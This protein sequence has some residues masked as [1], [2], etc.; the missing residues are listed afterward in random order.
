M[1]E[2]FCFGYAFGLLTP[3]LLHRFVI[4]AIKKWLKEKTKEW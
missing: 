2:A 3:Y 1:I 4:P